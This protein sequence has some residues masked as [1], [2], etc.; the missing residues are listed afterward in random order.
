MIAGFGGELI[1]H[2]YV[3]QRLLD[4][5]DG[6]RLIAFEREL[7]RWWNRVSRS[8]GPA[9]SVRAIHD[10]ASIPLLQLLEYGRIAATPDTF[11]V[12]APLPDARGLLFSVPW[13]ASTSSIWGDA[14]R[15]GL[16]A[17]ASWVLVS[18]GRSLRII[19]CARSW[20]R[21]AIEFDFE[22]LTTS[23]K[24]VTALWHLAR[25]AVLGAG[26]ERSLRAHVSASDSHA[27]AVCRSLSDGVLAALPSLAEALACGRPASRDR[28]AAFDQALTLV[29]RILFLLFAEARALVPVWND[30]YRDVYT[31]AGL[32]DRAL[33]LESDSC[34]CRFRLWDALQ[35]ISRLAH[36][37]CSAGDLH[38]TA[39]NGRL[40]APRHTPLA[41]QRRVPDAVIR[42]VLLL[43]G[44]ES[45]KTG[46]RTVAY[47]DLGVE[48]LGS[49]YERVLE[50]QPSRQ[51]QRLTLERTSTL[52]KSTGSFYTPQALTE[53]LVGRTLAPLVEGRTA[54]QILELRVL[55]PAMGSGAFLV[56]ACRYLADCCEHAMARDGR[57]QGL[58]DQSMARATLRRSVAERC[59]YGV[60]LNPTAVQLA[61]L[62][63]WLTTLAADRPL[64]FLDHHLAAGDSLIGAWL[65]DLPRAP[66]PPRASRAPAALPL[67][68][69]VMAGDV[70]M[71]VLPERIRMAIE[72]SDS[73]GVVRTK[74]RALAALT[75][76]DG[77]MGKWRAAAD[78]WCAAAL[79]PGPS[80]SPGIVAEWIAAASGAATTLPSAQLTATLDRARALAGRHAAF[81]WELAFPE[82][83]FNAAGRPHASAGFDA[84]IGNPPWDMLRADSGS[85]A[86][87]HTARPRSSS[88]LNFFRRSG[89]YRRQGTGHPNRY[90]LFLERALQ[91]TRQ[92]GR[93]GLLLP[94]GVSTDHGSASLRRHLLDRTTIDTWIGFDN[95]RRIFPIHR[96]ARFVLMSTTNTGAT[97]ALRFRCGVTDP[98]VLHRDDAGQTLTL[99]RA[100]IEALSPQHLTIPK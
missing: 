34:S 24:G 9:S 47:H 76:E 14:V 27:S 10:V 4:G 100:R 67:L 90:Q 68:D 92:G 23:P 71:R 74:E 87:R 97:A 85:A 15:Q 99:A 81:H 45:T 32:I 56:A 11:G 36:A 12:R 49:V 20:T 83:F 22:R 44:T 65:A 35:A 70:A 5:A 48:Q 43:L 66:G 51:G 57:W 50:Y 82:I 18:N 89:A 13:T 79:W 31:I 7:L 40:F 55:D 28:G 17:H 29:Y 3:E 30:L 42:E 26:G 77:P 69:D 53:F 2:A 91:L 41:D 93:I 86:E 52:R 96:S 1:S 64:T 37:G 95:R 39:F 6:H 84:V 94:S 38:V 88:A 62:S 19:D 33:R 61:R 21:A 98:A 75:G 73:V 72:P 78:A 80:P 46:R 58:A 54:E 8:L 63:L 60:D 59:L 16:A 25:A